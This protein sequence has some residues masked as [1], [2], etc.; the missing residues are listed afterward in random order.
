MVLVLYFKIQDT[1][2]DLITW[3]NHFNPCEFSKHPQKPY[4]ASP[5][6]AGMGVTTLSSHEHNG[7]TDHSCSILSNTS[8]IPYKLSLIFFYQCLW[9]TV[10][11]GW[12]REAKR[13]TD[14]NKGGSSWVCSCCICGNGWGLVCITTACF[15]SNLKLSTQNPWVLLPSQWLN[16]SLVKMNV[17]EIHFSSLPTSDL[18]LWKITRVH[19][20]RSPHNKKIK[21]K[22]SPLQNLCHGP[23]T[24]RRQAK[25]LF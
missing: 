12:G 3:H 18:C 2:L 17:S 11:T 4:T 8:Y 1:H 22:S 14:D 23:K 6:G 24:P 13:V 19:L 20:L 21:I 15:F 25:S 5:Y 10:K 9:L 16:K 7:W